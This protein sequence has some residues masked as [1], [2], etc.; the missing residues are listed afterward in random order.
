MT[1]PT[2]DIIDG[3][4]VAM[5]VRLRYDDGSSYNLATAMTGCNNLTGDGMQMYSEVED[6]RYCYSAPNW[7]GAG[8]QYSRQER[9]KPHHITVTGMRHQERPDMT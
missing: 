4:Q 2:P 6:Y 7:F 1:I 8:Y 5:R 9:S 3:K